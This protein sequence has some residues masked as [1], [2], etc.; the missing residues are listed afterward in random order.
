MAKLWLT[1]SVNTFWGSL[2]RIAYWLAAIVISSFYVQDYSLQS[3]FK[4][5]LMLISLL[6]V[7]GFIALARILD[8][9]FKTTKV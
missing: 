8:H 2:I 9:F 1:D 4:I 5:G 3:Y 6:F 7:V